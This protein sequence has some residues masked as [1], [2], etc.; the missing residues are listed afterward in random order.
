MM[1][2]LEDKLK[3]LVLEDVEFILDNKTIKRGK[4]KLFNTKQ[5][6]IR[7]KLE[8]DGETKDWELPYPYKLEQQLDGFI[9]NYCLSAFCPPTE[10]A[11]YKMKLTSKATA[12]KLHDTHLR[13]VVTHSEA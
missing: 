7:F 5:F 11:Y 10:I 3:G 2:K 6:F 12:S 8:L 4:I 13:A 1:N 9:F